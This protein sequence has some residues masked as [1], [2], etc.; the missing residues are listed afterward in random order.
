MGFSLIFYPELNF[1]LSTADIETES[2]QF[3]LHHNSIFQ[4]MEGGAFDDLHKYIYK[5]LGHYINKYASSYKQSQAKTTA[6]PQKKKKLPR[7]VFTK[8][9]YL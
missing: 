2:Y 9:Q 5:N 1:A 6:W 8:I 7:N 3:T 4:T